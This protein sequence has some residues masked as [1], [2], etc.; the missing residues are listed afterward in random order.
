MKPALPEP[1]PTN[2]RFGLHFRV[3]ITSAQFKAQQGASPSVLAP[4][5]NPWIE[6]WQPWPGAQRGSGRTHWA[7]LR[8]FVRAR[9]A[10]RILL[11]ELRTREAGR[12]G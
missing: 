1:E 9:M 5:T 2:D 4:W 8:A 3:E 6:P 10:F 12:D 7:K 11:Q